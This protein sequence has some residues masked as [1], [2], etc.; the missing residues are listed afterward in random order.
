MYLTECTVEEDI[1]GLMTNN[2]LIAM[3]SQT[4]LKALHFCQV[5][6]YCFCIRFTTLKE[7]FHFFSSLFE[8]IVSHH[9]NV[10][11]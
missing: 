5:L 11:H 10:K 6:T 9:V 8:R 7:G 2:K 4:A 1:R 3:I